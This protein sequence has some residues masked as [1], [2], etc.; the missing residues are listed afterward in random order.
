MIEP[1]MPG[2]TKPSRALPPA[3]RPA[4]PAIAASPGRRFRVLHWTLLSLVGVTALVFLAP[5][6]NSDPVREAAAATPPPAEEKTT[7]E[8]TATPALPALSLP[9]ATAP[10][11]KDLPKPDR[12]ARRADA[13][14]DRQFI[15]SLS[16]EFK[17]EEWEY[18]NRDNRRY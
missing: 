4:R 2:P 6:V 15:P 7:P 13:V 9:P 8:L 16:F 5:L 1:N 12:E 11:K 3:R 14:F 10:S 17:S 18:L